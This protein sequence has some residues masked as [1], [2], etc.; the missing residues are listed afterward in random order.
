MTYPINMSSKDASTGV[1]Q[2]KILLDIR[3]IVVKAECTL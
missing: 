1:L 2:L 3:R